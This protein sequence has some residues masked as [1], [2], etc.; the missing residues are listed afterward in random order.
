MVHRDSVDLAWY[1]TWS[2]HDVGRQEFNM[3]SV[4]MYIA[5]YGKKCSDPLLF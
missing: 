3:Q 5:I 1:L 4:Y 2:Y